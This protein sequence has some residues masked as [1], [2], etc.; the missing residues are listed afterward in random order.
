MRRA[1]ILASAMRSIDEFFASEGRSAVSDWDRQYFALHRDRYG[2]ILDDVD[3][4][5]KDKRVLEVGSVPCHFTALLKMAGYDAAGVDPHPER[6][7]ALIR[8]FSLE[9]VKCDIE[10]ERLPY[11][12]SSF[13]TIVFCEVLEHMY[14]DPLHALS[15]LARVLAPGGRLLLYTDN[16][17]SIRTF[18]RFLLGEGITDAVKEWEKLRTIGHRGH[19]RLYSR[20][21]VAGLV[22]LAGLVPIESKYYHYNEI[23]SR[24]SAVVYGLL[25]GRFSP[26]QLVV[27]TKE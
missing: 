17:Y 12:D 23:K 26:N 2:T 24:R 16:L 15:E 8:R 6:A 21:E 7:E 13:R 11:A 19:I 25:P 27:A 18:K 10:T 9:V 5:S 14:I 22:S 1:D 3:R 20:K 4:Y